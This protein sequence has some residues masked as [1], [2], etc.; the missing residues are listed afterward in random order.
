[1]S[2]K[3]DHYQKNVDRIHHKEIQD[4]DSEDLMQNLKITILNGVTCIECPPLPS[5]LSFREILEDDFEQCSII[6]HQ[7]KVL[8]VDGEYVEVEDMI[9]SSN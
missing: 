3:T 4:P 1:M 5:K 2:V 8:D 6:D 9:P 7:E